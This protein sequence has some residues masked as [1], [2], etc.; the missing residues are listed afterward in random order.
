MKMTKLKVFLISLIVLG[1]GL[2][3]SSKNVYKYCFSEGHC[4]RFWEIF[5]SVEP[6]FFILI[7]ILL[8]SIVTYFIKE[9]VFK[10]WLKFTYFYIPIYVLAILLLSDN[11]GG[12]FGP[13]FDSEF[14][15]LTLS[16][17]YLII[18]FILVIGNAISLKA[19]KK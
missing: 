11:R 15:A 1:V 5:N 9:G 17:L 8:F 12:G 19:S 18:S 16:G 2:L 14:F 7:P 4:W 13:I 10:A 3:L 6:Y